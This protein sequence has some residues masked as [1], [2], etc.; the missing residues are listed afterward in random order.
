VLFSFIFLGTTNGFQHRHP[1]G[2]SED[3][4]HA[5]KAA[6]EAL[7]NL[8]VEQHKAWMIAVGKIMKTLGE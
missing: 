6:I 2:V 7:E 8:T 4:A 3:A 1:E 5:P